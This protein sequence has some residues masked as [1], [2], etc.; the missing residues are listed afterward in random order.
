MTPPKK[1][2]D[3]GK[4]PLPTIATHVVDDATVFIAHGLMQKIEPVLTNDINDIETIEGICGEVYI[5]L[6]VIVRANERIGAKTRPE[7][8]LEQL[9]NN[10]KMKT[11]VMA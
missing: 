9:V 2:G 1:L 10:L 11:P 8:E 3:P 7:V 5:G 4:R 6:G